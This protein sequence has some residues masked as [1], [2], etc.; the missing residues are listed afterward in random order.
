MRAFGLYVN[1]IQNYWR[2]D[3]QF[4]ERAYETGD[5]SLN[6]K[7]RLPLILSFGNSLHN[8]HHRRPGRARPAAPREAKPPGLRFKAYAS[9]LANS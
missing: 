8:N 1:L 9:G 7:E 3:R 6:I 2:H 4:G 5:N